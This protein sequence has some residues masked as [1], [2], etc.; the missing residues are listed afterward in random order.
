M[1]RPDYDLFL[2]SANTNNIPSVQVFKTEFAQDLGQD[3]DAGN[4]DSEDQDLER[5]R[6]AVRDWRAGNSPLRA[7]MFK[8]S[9]AAYVDS[10]Y[11]QQKSC[12]VIL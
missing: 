3:M 11:A 7:G 2:R 4:D 8:S 5:S 6:Q 1:F 10:S 12:C 9:A